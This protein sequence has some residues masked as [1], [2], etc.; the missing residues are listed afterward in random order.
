MISSFAVVVASSPP[1]CDRARRRRAASIGGR[2]YSI[3]VAWS[4]AH[5]LPSVTSSGRARGDGD[6][7]GRRPSRAGAAAAPARTSPTSGRRSGPATGMAGAG[8]RPRRRSGRA[9]ARPRTRRAVAPARPS[10]VAAARPRRGR[11]GA[12]A[13]VGGRRPSRR[14]AIAA[15]PRPTAGARTAARSGRSRAKTSTPTTTD[16]EQDDERAGAGQQGLEGVGEEACRSRPPLRCLE[17]PRGEQPTMPSRDGDRRARR[18]GQP[19]ARS[20]P[21]RPLEV[22]AREPRSRNGSSQRIAPNHGANDVRST[23]SVSAPLPGQ[24]A[25]AMSVIAPRTSRTIPTIERTTSGVI[26]RAN[27]APARRVAA[28]VARPAC[29]SS[30]VGGSPSSRPRPRPGRPSAGASSARTGSARRRP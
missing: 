11:G 2:T 18:S 10:P 24:D 13:G 26:R 28:V 3:A 30:R 15:A 19:P 4:A 16:R 6:R 1:A 12:A 5:R 9:T 17:E 21:R 22:P 14:G 27:A 29:G 23:S 20:G 8:R 7:R 25:G